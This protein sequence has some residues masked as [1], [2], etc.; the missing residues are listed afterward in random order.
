M[1]F[2]N[3]NC[4]YGGF[5]CGEHHSIAQT[6]HEKKNPHVHGGGLI[7]SSSGKLR[8]PINR[9]YGDRI[10]LTIYVTGDTSRVSEALQETLSKHGVGF[11]ATG[12]ENRGRHGKIITFRDIPAE[13][14][15]Q[16]GKAVAEIERNQSMSRSR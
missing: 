11:K 14:L 7:D 15:P 8:R 6:P 1:A 10:A 16:L 9:E 12:W 4:K 3:E 5:S 2:G 13:Q